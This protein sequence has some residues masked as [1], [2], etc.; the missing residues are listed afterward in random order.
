VRA[1]VAAVLAS[2]S[3]KVCAPCLAGPIC[4]VISLKVM[5]RRLRHAGMT[6]RGTRHGGAACCGGNEQG[7][8][9]GRPKRRS[10]AAEALSSRAVR[11]PSA[12]EGRTCTSSR[13]SGRNSGRA[14]TRGHRSRRP[15]GNPERCAC[16]ALVHVTAQVPVVDVGALIDDATGSL[17]VHKVSVGLADGEAAGHPFH[18]V[19]GPAPP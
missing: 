1:V 16:R 9:A 5:S 15:A 7:G 4:T 12:R 6:L 2:R 17:Q 11:Q 10:R 3:Q 19:P 14:F 8:A 13:T 18:P